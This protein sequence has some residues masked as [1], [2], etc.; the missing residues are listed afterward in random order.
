VSLHISEADVR[1]PTIAEWEELLIRLE[2]APRALRIAVEEAPD[3]HSLRAALRTLLADEALRIRQIDAMTEGAPLPAV[4]DA[5]SA[6][7]QALAESNDVSAERLAVEFA[8]VRARLFAR[9]QRRGIEVWNWAGAL[10]DGTTLSA[11]QLLA[12]AMRH[13]AELLATVRAAVREG[14]ARC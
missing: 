12:G 2:I 14:A 9:A 7:A 13:D 5:A 11:Y 4:A 3:T 10:P 6:D 8:R 1:P